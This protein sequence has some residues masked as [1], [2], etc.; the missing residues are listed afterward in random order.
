MIYFVGCKDNK[1][2]EQRYKQWAKVLHSDT[3]GNDKQFQDM[4]LEY[5]TIKSGKKVNQKE[6]KE[7]EVKKVKTKVDPDEM[8]VFAGNIISLVKSGLEL[9]KEIN[10][11][12][13]TDKQLNN[14]KDNEC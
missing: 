7:P 6:N 9:A 4:Q 12:I 5:A 2:I 3:G 1:E 10:T 8:I 13:E 14:L 11:Y